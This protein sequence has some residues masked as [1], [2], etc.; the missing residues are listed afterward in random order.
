MDSRFTGASQSLLHTST[1]NIHFLS[2]ISL[3]KDV[4]SVYKHQICSLAL[5]QMIFH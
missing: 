3:V 2:S 4:Y 5:V 1:D